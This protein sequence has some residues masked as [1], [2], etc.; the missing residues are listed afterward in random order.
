[1]KDETKKLLEDALN[2]R[3][4]M[5]IGGLTYDAAGKI[6]KKYIDHYNEKAKRI[7]KEYGVPHKPLSVIGFLR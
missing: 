3:Y 5:K 7:S 6:V 1:M 2:A 4:K